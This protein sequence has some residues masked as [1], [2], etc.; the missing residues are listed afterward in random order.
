[1]KEDEWISMEKGNRFA[2]QRAAGFLFSKIPI[3]RP[4]IHLLAAAFSQ[5]NLQASSPPF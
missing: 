3:A 5:G 1:V 2:P 4:A